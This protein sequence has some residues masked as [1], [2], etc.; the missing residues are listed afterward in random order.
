MLTCRILTNIKQVKRMAI[1]S[2]LMAGLAGPLLFSCE[3][4][5]LNKS[6]I[7]QSLT[8]SRVEVPAGESCQLSCTATDPDGESIR[9]RWSA[10]GGS[11]ETTTGSPVRW[12]APEVSSEK[13]FTVSVEARD[14]KG[15]TASQSIELTVTPKTK[16]WKTIDDF[17]SYT[18]N[19]WPG[20][21]TASANATDHSENYIDD[22]AHSGSQSLRLYGV[23]DGCWA[24]IALHSLPVD[25]P[26][27][28][29][30]A[31][32]TIYE[33]LTG[34]HPHRAK[35]MLRKGTSWDNPSRTLIK[36][37]GNRDITGTSGVSL[38]TYEVSNWYELKVS[39]R[40]NTDNKVEIHYWIDGDYKGFSIVSQHA[41]E[42]GMTNLGLSAPEGTAWFDDIQIKS[43]AEM[44]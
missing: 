28:L 26:F 15:A 3:S 6:P 19:E 35:V 2:G 44:P 27:T 43:G 12:V 14:T 23:V 9:Y 16:T 7:I 10:T 41:E 32:F 17:E 1:L 30:L 20:D 5:G 38:G 39:Y 36:F 33:T 31:V 8:A 11:L 22:H 42:S 21:W 29:K 13:T 4:T 40:I 18:V 34:C 37:K 25:P 24:A